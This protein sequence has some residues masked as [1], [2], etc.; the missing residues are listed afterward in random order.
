METLI[1]ILKQIFQIINRKLIKTK[2][3]KSLMKKNKLKV[4]YKNKVLKW[5]KINKLRVNKS[6]KYKVYKVS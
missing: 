2:V 6:Q 4:K 5:V 3:N 1:K